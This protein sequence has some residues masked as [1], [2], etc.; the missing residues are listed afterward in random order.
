MKNLA[1]V[2]NYLKRL[3]I[4]NMPNDFIVAEKFKYGLTDNEIQKGIS[5]FREFLYELFDR[6]A[7]DWI[8]AEKGKQYNPDSGEDSITKCFPV[9][10]D[11][12]VILSSLG[13]YGRLETEPR[14]MLVI[15]G[16]DLLTPLNDKKPP[17][18]NKIS[19]QR[20]TELF[21]YLSDMGFYFED[22]NSSEGINLS[23]IG[24][25]YVTYENDNNVILGLKL[26]GEAKANIKS[27]D[28]KFMT[29]FMRCD[30]YPLANT[31]LKAHVASAREFAN[32]QPPEV[33]EWIISL[34]KLLLD[35]KCKISCFFLSNT[36]GS[37]SFSYV[38]RKGKTVCRIA[39]GIN[40]YEIEIR[41]RH[42]RNEENI[43]AELPE[44]ML[45]IVKNIGGCGGC[46]ERNPDTFVSCRHGGAWTFTW[47]GED[48]ECCVFGGFIF[49]SP[50]WAER[51]T[52]NKWIEME[53]A[54]T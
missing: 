38:S 46:Q 47:D 12:A 6:I 24:T 17:A 43:L 14:M 5:A 9:I 21:D 20:K 54:V 19:N 8:D 25:F 1:D 31:T 30:F 11:L 16:S 23:K 45:N 51:E 35:N 52:L 7:K 13:L 33:R 3:V 15:N 40:S 22:L 27:G 2:C 49:K 29:T 44:N 32:A 48:Y 37:G 39:M 50:N 36:N 41:G 28:Q 34:E 53:L 10:Y 26:I 42:F 4:P 18:M